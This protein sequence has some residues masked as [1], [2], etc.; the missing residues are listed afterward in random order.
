[1]HIPMRA[2]YLAIAATLVA[3]MA[4]FTSCSNSQEERP[5]GLRLSGA[6]MGTTWRVTLSPDL[7][8][9]E[10][11][12]LQET[13]EIQLERVNQAMST[14]QANS[15]L[16]RLARTAPGNPLRVS[17]ATW[18]CLQLARE[19]HRASEGAF[20]PTVG[21]LVRLWG[22]GPGRS[23]GERQTQKP[24]PGE[25]ASA[26]A[27]V[28]LDRLAQDDPTRSLTPPEGGV[29][30]D[31]SAIAKGFA[32]DRVVDALERAGVENALVEV[33]GEMR[34][35]GERPGG[36]P[37]Q[38]AVEDPFPGSKAYQA[39]VAL[40]NRA[41]ATS[42]DYRNFRILEDGS[43]VSHTIDPRTGYP[44]AKP[45]ASASV[46][47]PTCAMADAWAT[48]LSVTGESGLG[49]IEKLPGVEARIVLHGTPEPSVVL[50][51]GWPRP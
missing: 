15:D 49:W 39:R 51:S 35:L 31:L 2:T 3:A 11:D 47:A 46:L 23:P 26:L 13:I 12:Q 40:T 42:G 8:E 29:E 22:F 6:T 19:V 1:M 43:R 30:L 45:P 21:P 20:D 25:I 37:W 28:G 5:V 16:S 24:D 4:V 33:G 34:A 36:G 27:Q 9:L 41:L 10:K 38:L 7:P 44:V 32:V 18:R 48:A 50:S 14:Y 17:S